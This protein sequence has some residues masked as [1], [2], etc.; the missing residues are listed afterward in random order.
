MLLNIDNNNKLIEVPIMEDKKDFL[1]L[2]V[3]GKC[4]ICTLDNDEEII[5]IIVEDRKNQYLILHELVHCL[6]MM[7]IPIINDCLNSI[8]D[9]I[10]ELDP[11][12]S[13][14]ITGWVNTVYTDLYDTDSGVDYS[15]FVNHEVQAYLID[16]VWKNDNGDIN[17]FISM[18]EDLTDYE[19]VLLDE[20]E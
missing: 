15:T 4:G 12:Y 11:D 18:V 1:N 3:K 8:C 9:G 10:N 5:G 17:Q 20:M 13:E 7:N 2:K 16:D 19:I 14:Y 6:Q